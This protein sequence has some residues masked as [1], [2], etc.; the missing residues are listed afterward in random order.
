MAL[1]LIQEI[2]Y[3][4]W[5]SARPNARIEGEKQGEH[6]VYTLETKREEGF[7]VRKIGITDSKVSKTIA[8]S[9]VLLYCTCSICHDSYSMTCC[10]YINFV[11]LSSTAYITQCHKMLLVT[12]I[13]RCK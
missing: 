13:H 5:P 10:V 12:H 1:L 2:C 11:R 4:Y 6:T 3:Q 9:L 8:C 7:L